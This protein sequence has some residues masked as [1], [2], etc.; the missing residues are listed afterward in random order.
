MSK[1]AYKDPPLFF[2]PLLHI[3]I[4]GVWDV[5]KPLY[6]RKKVMSPIY[7]T[8]SIIDL[9]WSKIIQVLML[10]ELANAAFYF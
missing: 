7:R 4:N 1:E 10:L 8:H 2:V 6:F 5:S 3:L 9:D